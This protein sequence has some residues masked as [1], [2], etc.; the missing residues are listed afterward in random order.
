MGGRAIEAGRD[1]RL[2][3]PL[4]L[5]DRRLDVEQRI[6]QRGRRDP[7]RGPGDR[8][9]VAPPVELARN[10]RR[11]DRI[12][13]PQCGEAEGLGEGPDRDQVWRLGNQRHDRLPAVLEVGLVDDDGRIRQ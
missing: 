5:G 1:Q 7:G 4:P 10:L 8:S 13:D 11:G 2:T 12:A 3:Q 6:A 9:G